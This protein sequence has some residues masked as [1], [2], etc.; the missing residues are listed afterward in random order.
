MLP[1]S[2]R[3][4]AYAGIM[5][6]PH[7]LC[8]GKLAKLPMALNF[9]DRPE[10]RMHPA[11]A[12]TSELKPPVRT[13]AAQPNEVAAMASYGLSP[14]PMACW[15]VYTSLLEHRGVDIGMRLPLARIIAASDCVHAFQDAHTL[16][17]RR[18]S[19]LQP[20]AIPTATPR[21]FTALT[22]FRTSGTAGRSRRYSRR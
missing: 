11:L 7:R 21:L 6:N 15:L 8:Q 5:A 3:L 12:S 2:S 22:I 4:M 14:T 18:S 10:E 20:V 19:P 1:T 17:A 13:P 16:V 9:P